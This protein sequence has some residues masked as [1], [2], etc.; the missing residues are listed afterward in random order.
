[1]AHNMTTINQG[2]TVM[3]QNISTMNPME[4]VQNIKHHAEVIVSMTRSKSPEKKDNKVAVDAKVPISV[5]PAVPAVAGI[6]AVKPPTKS[7][8]NLVPDAV[9][10]DSAII[11]ASPENPPAVE[12]L[13]PEVVVESDNGIGASTE[14]IENAGGVK[15]PVQ[16][17]EMVLS[18]KPIEPLPVLVVIPKKEPVD[19]E[20]LKSLLAH[21]CG[22][23]S[24]TEL[25]VAIINATKKPVFQH[26]EWKSASEVVLKLPHGSQKNLSELLKQKV[27]L[28]KHIVSQHEIVDNLVPVTD[29]CSLF[30][31]TELDKVYQDLSVKSGLTHNEGPAVAIQ[32]S[33]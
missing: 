10:I 12:D 16:V 13:E 23:M 8:Q 22:T 32:S 5:I 29:D 6:V 28:P 21:I 2:L 31:E 17:T 25:N 9:A 1:M 27:E 7:S 18:S 24:V 3:N 11:I 15:D 4:M 26:G 14:K 19:L 30:D 20:G 33:T